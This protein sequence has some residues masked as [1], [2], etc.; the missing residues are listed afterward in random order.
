MGNVPK[1]L[2][3]PLLFA[4]VLIPHALVLRALK[5]GY[6]FGKG[7]EKLNHLLLMD[8]YKLYNSSDNE[9][10]RLAR[11]LEIVS[12]DIGLKFGVDKCAVLK[13]KRRKQMQCKE[14]D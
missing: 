13:M 12:G 7:K 4:I 5:P 11:S 14:I 3:V 6:L 2:P 9:I 8:D 1:G 10:D